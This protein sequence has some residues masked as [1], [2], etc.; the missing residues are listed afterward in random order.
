MAKLDLRNKAI[1]LRKSGLSYSEILK[2]VSVAKSTLSD[3]FRNVGLSEPQKQ[4]LTQKKLAA[5][6]RGAL[7]RKDDR[8][9]RCKKIREESIIDVQGLGRNVYWLVGAALYWAEGSKE[10]EHNVA[11]PVI[12]SNSDGEMISFFYNWLIKICNIHPGEIYFELYIHEN[13][14]INLAKKHWA[15]VLNRDETDFERV[16]L[17]KN[18]SVSYR[19]NRGENYYG[20]LRVVVRKSSILNRKIMGWV[21]GMCQ[22]FTNYSGV[23]QWQ[24][25]G[26]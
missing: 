6:L 8:I 22:Q 18:K 16:R 5:A 20:V 23:V 26:L 1:L 9:N 15:K 3:W 7:R 25:S 11:S 10:K 13:A 14:N 2:Q 24:D 4:R 17:K 19:K 12:F 21:V